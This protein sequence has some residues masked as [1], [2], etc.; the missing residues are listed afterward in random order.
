MCLIVKILIEKKKKKKTKAITSQK[1][2]FNLSLDFITFVLN[3]DKEE[4]LG[5][6]DIPRII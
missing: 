6:S 4:I 2:E 5:Q 3:R 1:V